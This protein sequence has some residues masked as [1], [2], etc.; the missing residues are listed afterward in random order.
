MVAHICVFSTQET[1][2]EEF[3]KRIIRWYLMSSQPGRAILA[4]LSQEQLR[5][6]AAPG[7]CPQFTNKTKM[8]SYILLV[9]NS[10]RTGKLNMSG[11]KVL[12]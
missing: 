8:V 9:P 5:C 6:L 12:T 3:G 11:N 4:R 10:A 1:E 2:A 7:V